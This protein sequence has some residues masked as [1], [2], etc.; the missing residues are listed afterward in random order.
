MVAT[1]MAWDG[2][3]AW[4]LIISNSWYCHASEKKSGQSDRKQRPP[5]EHVVCGILPDRGTE[6]TAHVLSTSWGTRGA[7]E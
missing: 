5:H 6:S 7:G 2:S 1:D 3:E 4:M